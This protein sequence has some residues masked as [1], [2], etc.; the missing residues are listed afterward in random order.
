MANQGT[1]KVVWPKRAR[2]AAAT[3]LFFDALAERRSEQ[4]TAV[5]IGIGRA[6]PKVTAEHARQA[7]ICWDRFHVVAL[8]TRELDVVRR[9]PGTTYATPPMRLPQRS[10]R[11]RGG[12]CSNAPRT[13]LNRPGICGGLG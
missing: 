10:S 3:H 13:S 4:L 6:Y 1:G 5:S 8:A 2:T 11:V 7:V 9:A 12:R